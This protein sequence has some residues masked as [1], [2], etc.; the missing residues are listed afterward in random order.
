ML[1]SAIGFASLQLLATLS[2][3]PALAQTTL[4]IGGRVVDALSG[5]PVIGAEVSLNDGMARV[6]TTAEGRFRIGNLR[7]GSYTVHVVRLGYE[8]ASLAEVDAGTG[9]LE[10]VLVPA[11]IRLSEIVVAPGTFSFGG[12]APT[13]RQTMSRAEIDAVPQFAEDIFRAVNRLPGLTSADFTSRFSIRGGR[14]DETLIRIDGLEIYEPY[15]MKDF[16]DGAVSI[17][18]SEL[19]DGVELMTGGFPVRYGNYTSGVFNVTTRDAE[20]ERTRYGLG[21]SLINAR[22]MVEGTF[23]EGRGTF[24]ASGRRGYVDLVLK[25][26]GEGGVPSPAYHDVFAK[27]KYR[28]S[29]AHSVAINVLQANDSWTFDAQETTGF[30]D[31][32]NTLEDTR[33][34]YGNAYGWVTH[35]A[36]IGDRALVR[37][38][39]SVASVTSNRN[40][41]EYYAVDSS[42][43]YDIEARRDFSVFGLKQDWSIDLASRLAM[44]V[45]LEV[46]RLEAD[47]ATEHV[48]NQDPDN[49]YPDPT[50]FFPV[51]EQATLRREGSTVGAYAAARLRPLDRITLEL[52]SRYDRA[53]YTGDRDFSP[54]LNALVE[55]REG[56]NLRVGWGVFRQMQNVWDLS[57]LDASREYFPSERSS[58]VTASLEHSFAGG[59]V[60]RVEAY[61]KDGDRLRP[62]YRNWKGGIDVFPESNEDRIRVFPTTSVSR[63]IELHHRRNFSDRLSIRASYALAEVEEQ[64]TAIENV[65]EPRPLLF[66]PTH[67]APRDQRHA[68]NLDATYRPWES[69]SLT[70]S[71]TFHTGWPTTI[72]AT[73]EIPVQ[74]GGFETFIRPEP[75]YGARLP[76]YHR[77][78]ARLTKRTRFRGGDLRAFFEVSNLTNRTNVFGY[79]YFRAPTTDGS[80]VL[81]RDPEGGFVILPSLGVSWTGWR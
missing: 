28:F 53:D 65:N 80:F 41:G 49:P 52:G 69:W 31:T 22:G 68:L 66:A 3:P 59:G 46:R 2:A 74:G 70:G 47:Y 10:I 36:L 40:G 30:L 18:D 15:H 7:V 64:V 42:P 16:Q 55:L 78:D 44:D 39:A 11:A 56:T 19:I 1:R 13:A 35:E 37:T 45:G 24:F 23:D 20:D 75:I 26:L 57:I 54:R 33:N 72:Q 48:I 62:V 27:L 29:D 9:D 43:I 14:P 8:S 4:A 73:E 5:T 79:D 12:D 81:N 58:Q 32:I 17:I 25:V 63:G 60:L 6:S 71:Y 61:R 77:V 21:L 34:R 51:V 38:L 76:D 67:G 50:L